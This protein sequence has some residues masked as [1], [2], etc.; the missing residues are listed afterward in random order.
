MER[1][2]LRIGE[3]K[4]RIPVIQGGMGI[5]ISLSG[6][7]GAVAACGGI[8][9]ISTAQIGYREPEFEKDPLEANLKAIKKEIK[10]ARKTAMGG[11]LGVNIMA[12]TK[13]YGEYV[14]A[15]VNAGIDLIISGAGL[16]ALLPELVKGSRVKIAPIVSTEKS[17]S[18]LC[19][20]WDRKYKRV[21]DLVVIEGPQ[22][23]GHLGFTREQ[24]SIFTP[25]SY[26]EEIGKILSVIRQY[27]EKYSRHIPVVVAGGIYDRADMDRALELGADGVQMGTRFVTT[28]EC[29]ASMAYKQ[30]YLDSKKED[31]RIVD[32][33]VGMPG[34]A[35]ANEFIW[36]K[37]KRGVHG[38]CYQCLEKCNP[39][40]IPYCI[41]RALLNAVKGKMDEALIFCGANAWRTEKLEYVSDIMEEL[42]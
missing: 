11:I 40:E 2:A 33:P 36:N 35:I 22:A 26:R 18:V 21:P 7:A 5:G 39:A 34:R 3:L 24:L 31:I 4:A 42:N 38:K 9:V 37:S 28:Y 29:D 13:C 12:A 30:A 6:L 27:G 20:L 16:P 15:A 1:K 10:K 32:S 14:K 8:G 17:A 19:R 41:T 23:G 25:D